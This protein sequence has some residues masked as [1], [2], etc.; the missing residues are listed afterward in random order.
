VLLTDGEPEYEYIPVRV[1]I[2]LKQLASQQLWGRL[3]KQGRT[4]AIP[5]PVEG[6]EKW[7][8]E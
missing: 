7:R 5:L 8:R 1:I 3:I 4:K 2:V 6:R